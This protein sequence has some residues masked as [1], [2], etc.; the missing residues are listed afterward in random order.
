MSIDPHLRFLSGPSVMAQLMRDKDWSDSPLGPPEDWPQALRSVVNLL[1]GSAFPMFVAWG[2]QLAQLYNDPYAEIMG[3]KH[4]KGLGRP[5]LENWAEIRQDVG[6]LAEQAMQG[7]SRYLENL[8][9]RLRRSGGEGEEDTWFTFSYSP[10]QDESGAVAGM[11][12]ACIETTRTVLAEHELRARSDWL[13]A[14][15]DQAPG[16]AAVLRGPDHVFT[17]VNEAYRHLVGGRDVLGR[18]VAEALPEVASQGF[19]GWLD[20]VYRTGQPFIGRSVPAVISRGAG[21][22]PYE[23]FI[24]FMYQPLRDASGRVDGI[25]VQGHDVTEQHRAREALRLADRQKDEFLATLAHELRNPLAPIR[26]ATHLLRAPAASADM[27]GRATEILARQVDHM[28]RLLD[29]LMDIS[30]ITQQRLVLKR[31]RLSVA[32]AVESALEAARPLIDAKHHTLHTHIADPEA[33][34]DADPL[35]LTQ[36]LANLLNNAS[37]YTDP[38]GRIALDVRQ[39]G[40]SIVFTVT[41]NGIGLSESAIRNMFTMFAQEQTAL[42]RSEGGL[43]IGL[44]LAKGLVELHGGRITASSDGPGRGS[45]F[46]VELPAADAQV[47]AQDASPAAAAGTAR[48]RTVLLADD[49]SDAA[50]ALAELL[51]LEGHEVHTATH[52]LQAAEMAIALRPDVVVL[53]IGMPGLNG[54]EVAQRIRAQPW[55]AEPLLVAATGWGQEGDRQKATTAGFDR[56]LTKPFDP[57]QLL[58]LVAGR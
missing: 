9:L 51:R 44:A 12:C 4:P 41:D 43:G 47:A 2:P 35:R 42:E 48:P 54:Y 58:D 50:D 6:P 32:A 52:G 46:M 28:A 13:Q 38:G 57:Q 5:L 30:R 36:V 33:C 45:R 34:L 3:A 10:V 56:H 31:V 7:H 16:F 20:E 22:P 19:T 37:K 8:P 25:F 26:S 11:F 55:G 40:G 15:F 53:D 39:D 1:L 14:L 49:N 27:R 23:A 17:Q 24:D 21:E 18:S 29:D